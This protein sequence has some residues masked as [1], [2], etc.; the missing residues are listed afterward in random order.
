MT[1]DSAHKGD[2]LP[3]KREYLM[4]DRPWRPGDFLPYKSDEKISSEKTIPDARE[5]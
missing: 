1:C 4:G 2:E 5:A 3:N